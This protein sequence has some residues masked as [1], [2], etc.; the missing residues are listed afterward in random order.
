MHQIFLLLMKSTFLLFLFPTTVPASLPPSPPENIRIESTGREFL[1]RWHPPVITDG[2]I[3]SYLINY[4]IL[5]SLKVYTIVVKGNQSF[6]L[7]PFGDHIGQLFLISL[8]AENDYGLS[9][10]SVPRYIRTGCGNQQYIGTT[11]TQEVV[12]PLYPHEFHQGVLCVWNLFT[13]KTHT[14]SIHI[15]DMDLGTDNQGCAKHALLIESDKIKKKIC[16]KTSDIRL[17]D[18]DVRIVF[19]SKI[20]TVGKG[21]SLLVKAVVKNPKPPVNITLSHLG[22]VILVTWSPPPGNHLPMTSYKLCYRPLPRYSKICII[23]LANRGNRF[24]INTQG[25]KGQ[26]FLVT[27]TARIGDVES[28]FSM[29]KYFRAS[30]SK[31]VTVNPGQIINITS[32]G[33]PTSYPPG[34][35]CQLTVKTTDQ[36]PLRIRRI[37]IDIQNTTA[38]NSDF[39]KFTATKIERI[40]GTSR[41]SSTMIFSKSIAEVTFV[42]DSMIEGRGFLLQAIGRQN[43]VELTTAVFPYQQNGTSMS[44]IPSSLSTTSE[45]QVE[46]TVEELSFPTTNSLSSTIMSTITASSKRMITSPQRMTT[47]S[48]RMITS[49]QRMITSPQR[50]IT[51]QQRLIT[52]SQNII[53]STQNMATSPQNVDLTHAVD[54]NSTFFN[55]SSTNTVTSTA[56]IST[57]S[58]QNPKLV[59]EHYMTTL[60]ETHHGFTDSSTAIID[61]TIVSSTS[62]SDTSIIDNKYSVTPGRDISPTIN[63]TNNSTEVSSTDLNAS[64]PV[65]IMLMFKFNYSRETDLDTKSLVNDLRTELIPFFNKTNA[66][67]DLVVTR[68]RILRGIVPLQIRVIY[69]TIDLLDILKSNTTFKLIQ[70]VNKT[71]LYELMNTNQQWHYNLTLAISSLG[72]FR[73]SSNFASQEIKSPCD[74]I[75][76]VCHHCKTSR[77][78]KQ[79]VFCSF[80]IPSTTARNISSADTLMPATQY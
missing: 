1:V 57:S 30:C 78:A 35:I 55:Q 39:L 26:L 46:S 76:D 41:S 59:S 69:N 74:F 11:G 73:K 79:G 31:T 27:M 29:N 9:K 37:W 17:E 52:S 38:C 36:S 61:K 15:K 21:F 25:H 2:E 68:W 16:T 14:L 24:I 54:D 67:R 66:F 7:I 71:A 13:N 42:S 77:R 22:N 23:V 72:M 70:D 3:L 75:K 10:Q 51:S 63:R 20:G 18:S 5:P 34:V 12:S 47:S 80:N 56:G 60:Q 45:S 44:T 49:P 58:E 62:G 53:T 48:Q 43:T 33:Y 64:H 32:P 40:C 19:Q 50:M 4:N 28:E 65:Y 8:Q 6:A